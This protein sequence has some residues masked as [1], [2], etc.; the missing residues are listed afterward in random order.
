MLYFLSDEFTSV[1]FFCFI[2]CL[3]VTYSM[4]FC[5]Y[6]I[7]PRR[8]FFWKGCSGLAALLNSPEYIALYEQHLGLCGWLPSEAGS[9]LRHQ[10][11]Q[12]WNHAW[13]A[14]S[15]A[16]GCCSRHSNAELFAAK[17][18]ESQNHNNNNSNS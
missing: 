14:A 13:S 11:F 7:F 8:K 10:E 16:Q 5:V 15:R 9:C 1:V 2:T 18:R 12:C 6:W 17:L 4:C 3:C